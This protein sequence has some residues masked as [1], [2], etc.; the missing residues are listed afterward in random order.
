MNKSNLLWP[1]S[2]HQRCQIVHNNLAPKT[3][4]PETSRGKTRNHPRRLG[5]LAQSSSSCSWLEM[6]PP[7]QSQ[8]CSWLRGHSAP[9][10]LCPAKRQQDF[11]LNS[12]ALESLFSKVFSS[13]NRPNFGK[14]WECA[15]WQF[16]WYKKEHL[17]AFFFKSLICSAWQFFIIGLPLQGV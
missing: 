10:H 8:I 1:S 14:L 9:S 5:A 7:H 15:T 11:Y 4:W 13:K 16:H 17:K 6:R 12:Q 3:A 2:M